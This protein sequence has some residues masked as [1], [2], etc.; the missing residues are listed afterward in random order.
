MALVKRCQQGD[1][2]AFEALYRR[3]APAALRVARLIVGDWGLAEDCLQ[4]A[5]TRSWYAMNRFTLGL[6]FR[7]WF[8]KFT[9]NE[10]LRARR[11]RPWRASELSPFAETAPGTDSA[12]PQ[13]QVELRDAVAGA[14]ARLDPSHRAVVVLFYY[15]DFSEQQVADIL[16]LRVTTVKSRLHTARRRLAARLRR[17]GFGDEPG[18]A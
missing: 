4:E 3:H 18:L 8:L 5:A 2:P 16:G 15:A 11:R 13:D 10:A 7:P 1:I 12:N 9:T 6:P 17:E 14:V